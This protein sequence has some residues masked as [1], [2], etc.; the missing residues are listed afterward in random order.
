MTNRRKFITGLGA[1][2]TG[3][4]AAMGTGAFSS[5]RA[6]RSLSVSVADDNEAYLS[7]D[8]SVSDYAEET[9]STLELQF[10]GSNSGQNGQGINANADSFFKNVFK[11]ENQG[12]TRARVQLANDDF[13]GQGTSI[14][15]FPDGPMV[16]AYTDGQLAQSSGNSDATPFAASTAPTYW[17][18]TGSVGNQ[19]L[20]PGDDLYVHIG[21]YLND[22]TS[23]LPSSAS[24]DP[25]DIPDDIG[26]YA[27]TASNGNS[28][29]FS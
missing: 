14:G 21:F 11:I 5:V 3:S 28:S 20:G 25:A 19:D 23:E 6:E 26:F 4:A 18:N 12:T 8:A 17:S 10:D 24:T 15:Q 29:D 9:G 27:G 2:A 22:D 13:T 7:L 1:L 16:V